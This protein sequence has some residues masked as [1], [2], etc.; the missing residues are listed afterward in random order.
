VPAD[1]VE[2]FA[3]PRIAAG[4]LFRDQD[5]RLLLVKPTYKAGWDIP[6]GYVEQGES[7]LSAARREL[8]EELGVSWQIGRLMS[9]DWAPAEPEGDKLLF[10]FEGQVLPDDWRQEISLAASELSAAETFVDLVLRERLPDRLS[11]RVL[12][13]GQ[14]GCVYLEHGAPAI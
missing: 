3:H 9:V 5:G 14:H 13:A 12:A 11:R 2:R 10:V 1:E 6:G 7:P 8:Q 4:V